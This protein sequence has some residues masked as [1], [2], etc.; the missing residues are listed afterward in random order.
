MFPSAAPSCPSAVET[1]PAVHSETLSGSEQTV[2]VI[3]PVRNRSGVIVRCLDSVAAQTHAAVRLIVVDNGSGLRTVTSGYVAFFDSDDE[4]SPD[5]LAAMLSALRRSAGARWVLART[6]MIFPDGTAQV[7]HGVPHPTAVR[8]LLSA[9]VSTQ[10]LVAEAALLHEV[11]GWDETLTCWQDYELGFRLLRH[12]PQPAWCEQVFH[13]IYRTADSITGHS[14][15]ANASGIATALCRLAEQVETPSTF[16]RATG[17]AQQ[18]SAQCRR[19]LWPNKWKRLPPF[20]VLRATRNSCR[21]SAGGRCGYAHTLWP[22]GFVQKARR[23]LPNCCFV[24]SAP[25][26]VRC[27]SLIVWC[28]AYS[29]ATPPWADVPLGAWLCFGVRFAESHPTNCLICPFFLFF[30]TWRKIER[31]ISRLILREKDYV[32]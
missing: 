21:R 19:A 10:S 30:C 14:L 28:V 4:M 23:L 5:F 17:D 26:F 2:T 9:Q 29:V 24:P 6:R 18:L 16:P 32:W 25:D 31:P 11:G 12:A 3:V 27:P 7:R 1:V 22:V 20:P 13:R 15:S 8:H